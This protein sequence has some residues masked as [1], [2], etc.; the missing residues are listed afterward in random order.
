MDFRSHFNG[1]GP[2]PGKG[3]IDIEPLFEGCTLFVPN[4]EQPPSGDDLP[5]AIAEVLQKWMAS[6]PARCAKHCPS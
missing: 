1:H 2:E 5:I 6:M 3:L 4:P